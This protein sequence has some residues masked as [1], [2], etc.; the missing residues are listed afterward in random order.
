[1]RIYL[2]TILFLVSGTLLSAQSI[3]SHQSIIPTEDYDNVWVT[4]LATDS[5]ASSF[6]IYIKNEVALHKHLT[7]TEYVVVLEG[8]GIMKLGEIHKEVHAGDVIYIPANTPH[9]VK[10]SSKEPMKVLSIQSPYFAG[11]DRVFL[12]N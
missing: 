5:L 7:H 11:K 3:T 10:V 6:I 4:A 2:T 1:M 8:S 12:D 9:S